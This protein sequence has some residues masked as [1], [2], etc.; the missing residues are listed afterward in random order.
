MSVAVTGAYLQPATANYIVNPMLVTFDGTTTDGAVLREIPSVATLATIFVVAAVAARVGSRRTMS[1]GAMLVL[2]GSALVAG[3]PRLLVAEAGLAVQALGATVLLVVPLGVIGARLASV[4]ARATGFAVF[5][6]VCPMV[7]VLLPV[8]TSLL[9]EQTTWRVVALVWMVGAA[10][11]IVAIR[12]SMPADHLLRHGAGGAPGAPSRPRAELWTPVLAGLLCMG[13]AQTV[14]HASTDG[15]RSASVMVRAAA[16]VAV[17]LVLVIQLRRTSSPTLDV[18]LL[19]RPGVALLLV[20]LGLWCFTQLW[21]YM[22]LAFEYVYG[23]SVL[24]T[25]VLMMVPQL[26]GVVGARLAGPMLRRWGA[27]PVGVWMLA[28]AGVALIASATVRV[29]AP[30]WWALVVTCGYSFTAVAAGVPMTAALMDEAGPG[31]ESGAAAFRQAA[32][33]VGTVI[34]IAVMST[35]VF[36]AFDASLG[37]QI[38]AMGGDSATETQIAAELRTGATPA[39]VSTTYAV[40]VAQVQQVNAA[41]QRALLDGMAAHG[42]AAGGVSLLAAGLF[43]VARRRTQEPPRAVPSAVAVG[44]Y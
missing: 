34:G 26:C 32:I 21:Y 43:W 44:R 37:G 39:Q 13:L 5:S 6:M 23:R 12:W 1:I 18:D 25:A 28:A 14:S 3:A 22:T 8:L 20:V 41:Q 10:V 40:P 42:W 9:M 38:D 7:F 24:D 19:R 30:L 16:T 11:A 27:G 35:I 17:G 33:S 31:A 29:G 36:A 2:V 4:G 15:M